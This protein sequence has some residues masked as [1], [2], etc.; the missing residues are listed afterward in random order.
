MAVDVLTRFPAV[1]PAGTTLRVTLAGGTYPATLWTGHLG[2]LGPGTDRRATWTAS[3]TDHAFVFTHG[4]TANW[5]PGE[6]WY[7]F[8]A[9]EQATNERILVYR[10]RFTVTRD[11][12]AKVPWVSDNERILKGLLDYQAGRM[13]QGAAESFTIDGQ[14]FTH[15]SAEQ[16]SKLI[17]DYGARVQV[18]KNREYRQSTGNQRQ[19]RTTLV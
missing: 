3:G 15:T 14:S 7:S 2:I 19:V 4:D 1:V 8:I 16:I 12:L 9:E 13:E 11:I 18:E 10:G 5:T 6:Y 17:R